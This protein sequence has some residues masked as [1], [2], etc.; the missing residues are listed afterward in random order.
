MNKLIELG[1]GVNL[2]E[3]TLKLILGDEVD[4]KPKFKKHVYAQY[5]TAEEEGILEKATGKKRA[6][7]KKDILFVYIK[8]RKGN[9]ITL[10]N[11]MGGVM[12]MLSQQEKIEILLK[13]M[14]KTR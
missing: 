6:K 2:V 8:P 3:Q 5:I 12:H 13:T 11:S 7:N 1:T 14:R 10:P 4:L 9:K